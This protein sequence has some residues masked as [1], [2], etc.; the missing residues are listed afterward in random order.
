MSGEGSLVTVPEW[1][2]P[3]GPLRAGQQRCICGS[4]SRAIQD[5]RS[6]S[7][8]RPPGY[9]STIP[10]T[11]SP[12]IPMRQLLALLPR[13]A[14]SRRDR[15]AMFSGEKINVSENRA[16][17]HVALRAKRDRENLWSTARM[18]CRK[19][20]KSWTGWPPFSDQIRSAAWKGH[21]GKRIRNVINIGI[22]G[23][24]LGPEM[25][26][27][28]MREFRDPEHRRALRRQCRR[29]RFRQGDSGTRSP[30]DAVRDRVENLH[31]PGDHD[32]RRRRTRLDAEGNRR[33]GSA[34]RAISS[35]SRPTQRASKK[36][37]IDTANMFGFWD[38]VGGRYSM[39][40]AIG[41]STMIA[42]GPDNFRAML[43]GFH[44]MDEH[45]RT[46]PPERN[47]PMLMGL[48]TVWYN[49]FFNA[50]R[51]LPF[52]RIRPISGAFPLISS[53]CRWRAMASTSICRA[54]PSRCRPGQSSGGS[55]ARMASIRFTNSFTKVR[56]LIPCDFIGF[57]KPMSP[58]AHQH[59]LLMANVFAQAEALAFGKTQRTGCG[60]GLASGA[61][62]VQGVRRQPT[63]EYVI[64][65][66]QLTPHT[67][68]AL[69][70]L[71]EHSVFTQGASLE[72]RFLR[73]VGRRT[74]QSAC[75]CASRPN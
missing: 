72:H 30:R 65:A 44:A 51:R 67:L 12:T 35:R 15:D 75:E 61:T 24:Y 34:S 39:D 19:C 52:F 27:R 16:V 1:K 11:G 71:Y 42:I 60:R 5:A 25:A 2:S 74:R 40:S 13:R 32:Q 70:A 43:D 54:S 7:P 58:L 8:P 64:L 73:P 31:H 46:A 18:S 22:G 10:R 55:L 28:A 4:C 29:R 9:S 17:L 45:F 50:R 38:W 6:V 63:D 33:R 20:T 69:V 14:K 68:G 53:S 37:G 3:P 36:F 66:E 23:S 41:L 26:W 48:L 56:K 62:A 49:N 21:T 59:D 57:M 47:M